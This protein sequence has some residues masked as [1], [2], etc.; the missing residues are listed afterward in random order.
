MTQADL[1]QAITPFKPFRVITTSG[2]TYNVRHR[3]AYILTPTYIT[4]GLLPTPTGQVY[5]RSVTLDIFHVVGV[6][7]LPP[8]P[9]PTEGDGQTS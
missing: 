1:L 3:E 4:I 6:E 9:V 2:E 8:A 5:E 7:R